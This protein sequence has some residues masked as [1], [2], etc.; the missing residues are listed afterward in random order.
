[1]GTTEDNNFLHDESL[2]LDQLKKQ[3]FTLFVL[4]LPI[5]GLDSCPV[6]LIAIEEDD[7]EING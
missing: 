2:N 6:R 3:R 1:M 5:E 7:G 4:A